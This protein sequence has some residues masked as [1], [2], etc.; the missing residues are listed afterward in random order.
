MNRRSLENLRK[1]GPGRK[2]GQPNRAT[3]EIRDAARAI[4]ERPD[5][6]KKLTKR[7][8]EGKAPH[9]ETLLWHFA[10]GRPKEQVEHSG[11]V[12]MPTRVVHEYHIDGK[13]IPDTVAL[14]DGWNRNN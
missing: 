11:A 8:D 12:S 9:M 4:V 2:K 13:K 1:G 6:V 7:L 5:Y 3:V 10:Y 14:P